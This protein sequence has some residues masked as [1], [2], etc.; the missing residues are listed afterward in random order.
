MTTKIVT[1]A[2]EY[3]LKFDEKEDELRD[4]THQ[5][6]VRDFGKKWKN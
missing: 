6:L 3:T 5:E 1:V 4:R 2:P